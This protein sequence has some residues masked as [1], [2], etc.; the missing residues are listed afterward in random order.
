[1]TAFGHA[2]GL[3]RTHDP[4]QSSERQNMARVKNWGTRRD[5]NHGEITRCFQDLLCRVKDVS[6]VPGFVDLIV[7]RGRQVRLVE[8]K[9]PAKVPSQRRLTR[10]ESEFWAYWGEEPLIVETQA[11]VIRVVDGMLE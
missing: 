5:D 7:K 10:A 11:D 8:I 6:M 9:D 3:A 4:D 2:L 1:M